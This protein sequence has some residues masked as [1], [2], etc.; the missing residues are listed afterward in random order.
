MMLIRDFREKDLVHVSNLVVETFNR[1][2]NPEFYISLFERWKRGFLV[3]ED[4]RGVVGVLVAAISA[5][6]EARILLMAIR[7]EHRGKGIGTMLLSEFISRCFIAD[8]KSVSLE[9]RVSNESALRFYNNQ[10]FDVISLLPSYYE[11]G[12]AGYLMRKAL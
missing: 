10:G 6:K 5:P 4:E 12:E 11:D 3:V 7:P 9:V 8:I 2:Y 1:N